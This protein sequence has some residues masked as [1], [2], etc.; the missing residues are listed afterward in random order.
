MNVLYVSYTGAMESLGASQVLSYLTALSEDHQIDLISYEKPEDWSNERARAR[1][2]AALRA[3][4]IH[5]HPLPYH[6]RFSHLATAYDVS[7]GVLLGR[8]L[9]QTRGIQIVHARSYVASVVARA[10]QRS[11]GVRFIFDMRAFWPDE[12]ADIGAWSRTGPTYRV[13]KRLERDFLSN[14]DAIVSL[15]EAGARVLEE[16]PGR[17]A[18]MAKITVIP[19]CA[20]LDRFAPPATVPAPPLTVGYVGNASGW[21]RFEPVAVAF[22]AI[23]ES[24]PSARLSIVN[25]GQHDQIR[26]VLTEHGVPQAAVDLRELDFDDVPQAIQQMHV[27]V[28]FLEPYPSKE[29]S[30][31]TRLAEFLGCGV[32][33]LVRGGTGDA[34]RIVRDGN[35]G[36]VVDDATDA[37][38][39][40]AALQVMTLAYDAEARQRCVDTA[41]RVF[42]L[43]VGVQAYDTLYRRV[44]QGSLG[45]DSPASARL[46]DATHVSSNS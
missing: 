38:I 25:K 44:G 32:P 1:L 27:G 26:R 5:W 13:F 8:R 4:G 45:A 6:R 28:F 20:D 12:R 18:T 37:T 40:A 16:D 2:A 41:Q 46:S 21:Y 10:L 17:P 19:T 36:V 34:G 30:A 14:A 11:E 42:S 31:P 29:A 43:E 24:D 15:T 39:R 33:C 3:R 9:I 35:V 7:R 23:L 22:S